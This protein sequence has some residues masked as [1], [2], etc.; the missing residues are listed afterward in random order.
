MIRHGNEDGAVIVTLILI[1]ILLVIFS[2]AI[3]DNES[4][5]DKLQEQNEM[6]VERIEEIEEQQEIN[7]AINE[8]QWQH[9][10]EIETKNYVTKDYMRGSYDNLYDDVEEFAVYTLER[11]QR[12]EDMIDNALSVESLELYYTIAMLDVNI[13]YLESKDTLTSE[14]EAMLGFMELYR[15]ELR[16]DL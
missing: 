16:R 10:E 7:E 6:L 5:I 8:N 11:L 14:E 12:Q 9:I 1:S 4:D 3:L 15:I 13:E 2:I